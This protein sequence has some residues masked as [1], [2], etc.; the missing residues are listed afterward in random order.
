M[1]LSVIIIVLLAAV[2][3]FHYAQGLFA[4][5]VSAVCAGIAAL[6][7]FSYHET[8]V[9]RYTGG[10]MAS[11]GNAVVLCGMF[12]LIYLVLRMVIDN[13]MPGNVRYPVV[14]DKIGAAVMGLV[15]G[16]FG[17][18]IIA[19]A[20]QELP[21]GPKVAMYSVY[22]VEDVE[23]VVPRVLSRMYGIEEGED[24]WNVDQIVEIER[25]DTEEA[26]A[27]R[28]ELWVPVDTWFINLVSNLSD[29]GALAGVPLERVY[30]DFKTAMFGH[31]LGMQRAA[32]QVAL[33]LEE[34]KEQV[35]V[36]TIFRAT[37]EGDNAQYPGGIP[38]APGEIGRTFDDNLRPG[39]GKTLLVLRLQFDNSAGDDG[40]YV[41]FSPGTSR[42]VIA[43]RQY[44]PVATL[45]S[46]RIAVGH[47]PD[48][49]LLAGTGADLIYEVD[50]DTAIVNDNEL[51]DGAFLEFKRFGRVDLSGQRIFNVV[52]QDPNT[53]VLR[54]F[55]VQEFI[56]QRI[57]GGRQTGRTQ[58]SR[59]LYNDLRNSVPEEPVDPETAER[60]GPG[61]ALTP[62]TQPSD[63]EPATDQAPADEQPTTDEA[64]GD[65][66]LDSLQ[67]QAERRNNELEGGGEPD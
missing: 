12:A 56:S 19:I 66:A 57:S 31:R 32:S 14:M 35:R 29:T 46:G 26:Q 47:L 41:R 60:L 64:A 61:A 27:A 8:I 59:D 51:V 63:E 65:G 3:Y 28:R 39:P 17:T 58:S 18:A 44:Y 42:L 22:P 23:M 45:D 53:H 9:T 11:Y 6:M 36:P 34:G 21:F 16:F 2:A 48:D 30:P 37:T 7:A 4:A 50:T 20:A 40:G 5:T 52:T 1:L 55:V 13:M 25:L 62:G 33:N 43:G 38:Q 67:E 15:A 54:K 10:G 49:Y 24:T